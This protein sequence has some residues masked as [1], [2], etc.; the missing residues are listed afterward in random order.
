MAFRSPTGSSTIVGPGLPWRGFKLEDFVMMAPAPASTARPNVRPETPKNP[1]AS[2]VGLRNFNP[3]IS[4][5]RPLNK[6]HP[7]VNHDSACIE[8]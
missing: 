4:I 5:E 6:L 3:A 7:D 8:L 2:I 1:E